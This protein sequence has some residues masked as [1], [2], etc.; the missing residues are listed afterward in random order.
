MHICWLEKQPAKFFS[1]RAPLL[2]NIWQNGIFT[3]ERRQTNERVNGLWLSN[4]G[5][6]ALSFL[7]QPFVNIVHKGKISTLTWV[8][9]VGS[10]LQGHLEVTMA[11]R[12]HQNGYY[13]AFDQLSGLEVSSHL[14]KNRYICFYSMLDGRWFPAL[15]SGRTQGILNSIDWPS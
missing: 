14:A 15:N 12:G 6:G 11:S 10:D 13:P 1:G 4:E 2:I 9:E 5:G 3:S 7:S 8:I